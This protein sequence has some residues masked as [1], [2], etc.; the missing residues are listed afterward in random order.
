M[1]ENSLGDRIR[2]NKGRGM[3]KKKEKK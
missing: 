1:Y 3:K 2:R